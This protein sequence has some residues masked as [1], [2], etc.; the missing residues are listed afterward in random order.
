MRKYTPEEKKFM[1]EFV[2]GHSYKEIREEFTK[3]FGGPVP[4]DFPKSY[5]GNNK[6]NT[7]RTGYFEKG[8]VPPNKGKKMPPEVY[9]KAKA[10]MFTAGHK[11]ANTDPIG[12]EKMLGDG[13]IWVKIDDQPK[14]P[15]KVNWIQKHRKVYQEV[16]G[17]IP[18]E[19][20]VIFLDGDRTNFAPENLKAISKSENVRLNQ[21]GLRFPDR[22]LTETGIGIA[23]LLTK[24][25]TL[26]PTNTKRR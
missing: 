6:L 4:D 18:E 13:Y 2:P 11:P 10:T 16:Y 22:E 12:T 3:R 8:S 1:A 26:R 9:A 25:G 20:I 14:V 19:H 24:A 7:G 21:N 17:E 15:K 23:K 5:I